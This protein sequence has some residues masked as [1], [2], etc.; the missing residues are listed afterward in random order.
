M[1]QPMRR[2]ARV[3]AN[4]G[5]VM[6]ALRAI[7]CSVTDLSGVGAGVPD[8]LVG[9]RGISGLIEV[10]DGSKP[11]SERKLTRQQEEFHR[12]WRGRPPVVVT[13]IDEAIR[14]VSAWVA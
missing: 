2:A 6:A 3:D 11:P 5:A 13:S 8:L 9:F 1:E 12:L 7:G 10:K 14:E 4:Q